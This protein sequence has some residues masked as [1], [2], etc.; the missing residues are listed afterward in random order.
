MSY[1][2][3]RII[4]PSFAEEV[5]M[6]RKKTGMRTVL[7]LLTLAILSVFVFPAV[8]SRADEPDAIPEGAI[9]VSDLPG[10]THDLID[11]PGITDGINQGLVGEDP[12]MIINGTEYKK[13]SAHIRSPHPSLQ[14]L[15]QISVSTAMIILCSMCWPE[16]ITRQ[17]AEGRAIRSDSRSG[18]TVKRYIP[19][20]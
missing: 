16:K 18:R 11:S 12:K 17:K 9:I 20:K 8:P 1:Y 7:M 2:I 4:I 13:D 6:N 5:V 14:L 19:V 3:C 15:R 10:I